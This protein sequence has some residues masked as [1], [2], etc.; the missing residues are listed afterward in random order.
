M[1]KKKQTQTPALSW[2]ISPNL[3]LKFF[4]IGF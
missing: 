3:Y 1:E 2:L 4:L